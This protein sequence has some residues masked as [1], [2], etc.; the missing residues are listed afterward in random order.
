M[1]DLTND[2][3]ESKNLASEQPELVVNMLERLKDIEKTAVEPFVAKDVLEGNPNQNGGV[4]G[5]GW[6]NLLIC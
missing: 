2:P 4:W 3:Y 6:C 5:T 1:Y